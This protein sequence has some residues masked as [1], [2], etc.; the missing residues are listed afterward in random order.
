M[1]LPDDIVNITS[2]AWIDDATFTEVATVT[3]P[4]GTVPARS[5]TISSV[6]SATF[7]GH[8]KSGCGRLE[9]EM[10][11]V[12]CLFVFCFPWVELWGLFDG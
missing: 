8:K 10:G 4:V 7:P 6:T 9:R 3:I 11:V 1:F 2:T 5:S 12:V